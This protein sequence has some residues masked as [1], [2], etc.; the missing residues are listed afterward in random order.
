MVMASSLGHGVHV[1][2]DRRNL[3]VSVFHGRNLEN[4]RVRDFV[5]ALTVRQI[6]NMYV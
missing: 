6:R 3:E 4:K 5:I 2:V 1:V